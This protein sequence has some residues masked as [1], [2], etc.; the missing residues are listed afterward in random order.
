[1]M[2]IDL[3]NIYRKCAAVACVC[4]A[5]IT[6]P[7]ALAFTSGYFKNNSLLGSGRW[8]KIKVTDNGMHQI[9]DAELLAMGFS[10]PSKVA[11]YG[12]PAVSL[13]DYRL[14]EATPD[15]L[16]PAPSIYRDGKLIFYAEGDIHRRLYQTG[17]PSTG[18]KIP[19]EVTR[20]FYASYGT[21]FLTDAAPR[22]EP[23]V[24]PLA[25]DYSGTVTYGYGMVHMEDEKENP[26]Q[27][28]PY[29][30]GRSFISEPRQKYT[31]SMPGLISGTNAFMQLNAGFQTATAG[32]LSITAPSGLV[33]RVTV[34]NS[35][36]ASYYYTGMNWVGI[37]RPRTNAWDEYSI[38]FDA[39]TVSGLTFG[40]VDYLTVTYQR[41]NTFHGPQQMM[42]YGSLSATD[43]IEIPSSVSGLMVWDV[44][45]PCAPRAFEVGM[46][47]DE[48][49]SGERNTVVVSSPG[50]F[51]IASGTAASV[52]SFDPSAGLLPVEVVGEVGPQDLHSLATP[53]M[54]IIAASDMVAEA[55]R[56]AEA[57]RE[58]Q[59]IDVAVVSQDEVYNEFSSG[60]PHVMAIRRFVKMLYD[61]DPEKLRSVLLFGRASYDN[62]DFINSERPA[63]RATNIPIVHQEDIRFSGH[64]SKSFATDALVGMMKEDKGNSPFNIYMRDMDVNVSRI[65]ADNLG[66]ARNV[67]DKT[68]AYMKN[69]P[70]ARSLNAALLMCDKGDAVGHMLDAQQ[71][72]ELIAETAPSTVIY[73]GFNTIFP[74]ENGKASQLNKYI[75]NTLSKGVC[76][77]AYSGHATPTSFGAEP[78]WDVNL[79]QGAE[80]EVLPYTVFATCRAAYIDHPGV[81]LADACLFAPHGGS[82]VVVGALREVYKEKNQLMNLDM[83]RYF[84]GAAPGTTTGDVF[85][86]ARNTSVSNSSSI[87]DDQ[88]INTLSYNML[89]D[90]ELPICR[91]QYSAVI[92]A[93]NG[94]QFDASRNLELPFGSEVV[95]EGSVVDADGK[96]VTAFNGE[97]ALTLFDAERIA[98]VIN[99]GTASTEAAWKGYEVPMDDEVIYEAV[100]NVVGGRFAFTTYLPAPLRSGPNNRLTLIAS[101]RDNTMQASGSADNIYVT[102]AG[103][104]FS[105]AEDTAPEITEM[106]LDSPDFVNG[107]VVGGEVNFHATVGPNDFRV[108]GYTSLLGMSTSLTL[109]GSRSF[110]NAPLVFTPDTQGGGTVDLPI[111]DIADGPHTL[112]LK[113]VNYAGQSSSRT[114][115]FTTVNQAV[116]ASLAVEEYPASVS[117]TVTL[118][119][120]LSDNPVGRV[121]VRNASG[122]VV[123]TRDEVAFPYEWNLVSDS[124]EP[125]ADG[126]YTVEA[127][128]KSGLRYGTA[129]PA[130]IVVR[131]K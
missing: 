125:V 109:D 56:L 32:T 54:V 45:D 61:R 122:E 119:H 9:T 4:A 91:P 40:S 11:V 68:I 19:V 113:V 27:M 58:F 7:E 41:D 52:V 60:T 131:R 115:N 46:P 51:A 90:P 18:I 72:E 1:M 67:V 57:H 42:V 73:K 2:K 121:V 80:N 77:W 79:T 36:A 103:G 8:I 25:G 102:T 108:A 26:A 15:D 10:D 53:R 6:A 93:V 111:S 85:R 74:Q 128:L 20:N 43:C 28:G 48:V 35:D 47:D 59:G 44:T 105:T 126:P 118:T 16:P 22:V 3:K 120:N 124:G 13:S 95:F 98:P 106:Y 100:A 97:I 5:V 114:I 112:T 23:Q 39:S 87:N 66:D 84:F 38:T 82:I 83:G 130:E 78:V 65:P 29:F 96:A 31:F 64:H 63:F 117:A 76:Y 107:D 34:A 55:T 101:S 69:P 86:M 75:S 24:I 12:F 30:F 62:R 33:S 21:Y 37:D 88:I 99:V 116:A 70:H 81:S 123:H 17:S 89:G 92:T 104:G 49:S 71:L 14:T 94:Q 50:T 127:Y 129:I 110:A